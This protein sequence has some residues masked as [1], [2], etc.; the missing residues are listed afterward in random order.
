MN[1][2]SSTCLRQFESSSP[3]DVVFDGRD[4]VLNRSKTLGFPSLLIS[5]I[6][7]RHL[8][9]TASPDLC[10]GPRLFGF[11]LLSSKALGLCL[12]L[13]RDL[14]LPMALWGELNGRAG[15]VR[16]LD[17]LRNR[18]AGSGATTFRLLFSRRGSGNAHLRE[19]QF[20]RSILRR[21][22]FCRRLFLL[23]GCPQGSLNLPALEQKSASGPAGWPGAFADRCAS[24]MA[25]RFSTSAVRLHPGSMLR[26]KRRTSKFPTAARK[27]CIETVYRFE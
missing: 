11:S 27:P 6:C 4:E 17:S 22:F 18:R 21:R 12:F 1:E 10:C 2:T 9:P 5:S 8:C 25:I 20:H 15:F 13:S 19:R 26:Q 7:E 3:N 23:H 16:L 24:W 14:R